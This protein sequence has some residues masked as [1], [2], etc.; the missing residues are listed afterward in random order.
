MKKLLK[1]TGKYFALVKFSHTVFAMPFALVGFFLGSEYNGGIFSIRLFILVIACMVFARS[2]AMGFNRLADH[3]IDAQNP[4]TAT[5]EIPS[6]K[7]SRR[8]ALVFVIV[9]S[10]LFIITTAFINTLT[11]A[12]SP[13]A[14]AVVLGYSYTKRFTPL[15]HLVLGLGLSL[16]PIGAYIAVTGRFDIL[17]VIY[18]LLVLTWVSGFDIIY[19]LQDDEFDREKGLYSIPAVFSRRG[20]LMISVILHLITAA[21]VVSAG[22]AGKAGLIYWAGAVVFLGLLTF[23]HMIVRP[24]NLSRVNVAF[25]TTNGVAGLLFGLFVITDLLAGKV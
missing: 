23:Q 12:L 16:A 9:S 20:A 17:P 19:A 11:L 7:V 3:H 8:S 24:D 10:V 4:R 5:R 15:C 25:G 21:M 18:S 13:V 6:G 22:I 1:T 2:A 14:L